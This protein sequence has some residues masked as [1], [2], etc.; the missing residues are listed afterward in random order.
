MVEFLPTTPISQSDAPFLV[1]GAV[2]NW[3]CNSATDLTQPALMT[4]KPLQA[5]CQLVY[6]V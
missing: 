5:Q 6:K 3:Q 1:S 2:Q 4:S